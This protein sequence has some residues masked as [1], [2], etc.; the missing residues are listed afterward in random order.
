MLTF[1]MHYLSELFNRTVMGAAEVN[2]ISISW[3]KIWSNI[4]HTMFQ[5]QITKI[6]FLTVSIT[7]YLV[8]LK[9]III[10]RLPNW[11]PPNSC[12][13]NTH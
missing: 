7:K 3:I 6:R 8:L 2:Q 1:D 12:I 5:N 11:N 10:I 4:V 13:G 9:N